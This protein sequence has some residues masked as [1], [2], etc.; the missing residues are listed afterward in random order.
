MGP[1]YL[2]FAEHGRALGPSTTRPSLG[3]PGLSSWS[4]WSSIGDPWTA[5]ELSLQLTERLGTHAKTM[6]MERQSLLG[7]S[8]LG[9]RSVRPRKR[10]TTEE[11][12]ARHNPAAQSG[13][14]SE[15][16]TG[17]KKRNAFQGWR[18]WKNGWKIFVFM[19]TSPYPSL[20][21]L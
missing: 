13:S 17:I 10:K 1:R 18:T 15:R 16:E 14:R 12:K 6:T 7:R 3:T 19:A 5:R 11:E 2:R 9:R 21:T 4:S 20:Q 8:V